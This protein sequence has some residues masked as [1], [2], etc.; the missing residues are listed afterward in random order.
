MSRASPL[1]VDE[2]K[3]VAAGFGL[4]FPT[5]LWTR[6]VDELGGRIPLR[7]EAVEE[8]SWTPAGTPFAQVSNTVVGFGELV[9]WFEAPLLHAH[10]S[11]ACAT[12]AKAMR[13][14]LEGLMAERGYPAS[15]LQ[16]FHS[17][18]FRGHRSLEDA[19][20]AG[21]AWALFLSGSDDLHIGLH[22][23]EAGLRSIPALAHKVVQQFDSEMACYTHAVV[24]A[25]RGPLRSG[26]PRDAALTP[27]HCTFAHPRACARSTQPPPTPRLWPS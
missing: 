13:D 21:S 4:S 22:H 20:W 10:F 3:S 23:P 11:S 15:F 18:G 5:A 12:E 14:Y 9:T 26:S 8:G 24:R 2:A 16:R 7:V 19:Y 17:F 27:R 1:Q 25:R 6:V